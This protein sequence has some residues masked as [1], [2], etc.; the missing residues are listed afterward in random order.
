MGDAVDILNLERPTKPALHRILYGSSLNAGVAKKAPSKSDSK[1]SS[2][3]REMRLLSGSVGFHAEELTTL[4]PT[5]T[6][7]FKQSR[8]REGAAGK[9]LW[10]KF[11][12]SARSDQ[13]ELFH[14]QKSTVVLDDYHFA[15]FNKSLGARDFVM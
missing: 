7:S 9:W 11:T 1:H 8:R 10:Q 12:N 15:K 4:V 6:L 3:H 14:W 2:L 5:E 13:L